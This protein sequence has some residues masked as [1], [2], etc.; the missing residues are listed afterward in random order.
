MIIYEYLFKID[1]SI[2]QSYT[3]KMSVNIKNLSEEEN[4]PGILRCCPFEVENRN[5]SYTAYTKYKRAMLDYTVYKKEMEGV[6]LSAWLENGYIAFYLKERNDEKA[7]NIVR[8][9]YEKE[10]E[11]MRN[12][13]EK[14]TNQIDNMDQWTVIDHEM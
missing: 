12:A 11:K 13:I 3:Q 5:N 6:P 1:D 2:R 4:R 10:I 7:K 14:Y 8:E 9:Y